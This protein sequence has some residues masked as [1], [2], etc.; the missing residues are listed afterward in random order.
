LRIALKFEMASTPA[1][2]TVTARGLAHFGGAIFLDPAAHFGPEAIGFAH[3]NSPYLWRIT[4]SDWLVYASVNLFAPHSVTVF[5]SPLTAANSQD[6][7]IAV[8]ALFDAKRDSH[9]DTLERPK[10]ISP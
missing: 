5:S 9:S 1:D 3:R 4:M 6:R 10:W 2:I 8:P 7:M